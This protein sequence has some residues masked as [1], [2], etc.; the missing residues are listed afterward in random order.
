MGRKPNRGGTPFELITNANPPGST[1]RSPAYDPAMEELCASMEEFGLI[2]P[3]LVFPDY[4]IIDGARRLKAADEI[5]WTHIPA[6]VTDQWGVIKETFLLAR[7]TE[8]KG[9]PSVPMRWHELSE[10]R[11][12]MLT[13]IY[14]SQV[15]APQGRASRKAGIKRTSEKVYNDSDIAFA[16][17]FGLADFKAARSI[18]S[19][20]A[21]MDRLKTERPDKYDEVFAATLR[22][23]RNGQTPHMGIALINRA[24]NRLDTNGLPEYDPEA[25]AIQLEK[26]RRAMTLYE[27]TCEQI[28]AL[29]AL[30]PA[31]SEEAASNLKARL[32]RGSERLRTLRK[33]LGQLSHTEERENEDGTSNE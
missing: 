23:E 29:G 33:S 10:V 32:N 30:N 16:K 8:A 22:H 25:A 20:A 5:G 14:R 21:A 17:M 7:T 26:L 4:R 27:D 13:S 18:N 31:A 24:L 11:R 6:V 28:Q 12:G 3:I 2:V 9:W 1:V 19:L 15:A